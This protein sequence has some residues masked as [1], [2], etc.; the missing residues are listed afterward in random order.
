M[1]R[2][3]GT[4]VVYKRQIIST[5]K[6]FSSGQNVTVRF[7]RRRVFEDERG[8][9]FVF[10]HL[11]TVCVSSLWLQFAG[12]VCDRLGQIKVARCVGMSTG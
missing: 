2:K 12:V 7:E 8:V 1:G 11:L 10:L 4:A 9:P 3:L 6:E 5:A